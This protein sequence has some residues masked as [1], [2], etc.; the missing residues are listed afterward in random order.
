MHDYFVA[1]LLLALPAAWLLGI[2]LGSRCPGPTGSG[3]IPALS[4]L[5][6]GLRRCRQDLPHPVA[7]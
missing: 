1:V 6:A 7:L 4:M 5:L 2:G 3:W